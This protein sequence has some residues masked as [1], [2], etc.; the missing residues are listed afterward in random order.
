M[1]YAGGSYGGRRHPRAGG[2]WSDR[3]LG[4]PGDAEMMA[5]RVEQ[6]LSDGE[7]RGK[8]GTQAAKVARSRFDLEQQVSEYLNWYQEI[9]E[10]WQ[11][12][13]GESHALSNLN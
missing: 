12:K 10:D 7:L 9:L 11:L 5:S 8:M 4:P 3:V 2:A 1:W 13:K 6:L